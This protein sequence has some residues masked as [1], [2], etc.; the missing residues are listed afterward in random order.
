LNR[1]PA[2][3]TWERPRHRHKYKDKRIFED[4]A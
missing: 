2:Q 1:Q 3:G 4:D